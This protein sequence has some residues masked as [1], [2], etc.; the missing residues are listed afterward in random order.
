MCNK[1]TS[2][3]NL[4]DKLHDEELTKKHHRTFKF[5]R[6]YDEKDPISLVECM[7]NQLMELDHTRKSLKTFREYL[8]EHDVLQEFA[9]QERDN[10]LE[11]I[12]G[13]LNQTFDEMDL[14]PSL[15]E[16]AAHLLYMVI[17]RH[18]FKDGNKRSA[19]F[20][21]IKFL[22]YNKEYNEYVSDLDDV[23]LAC[24]VLLIAQSVPEQKDDVIW[25]IR[26]IL[27]TRTTNFLHF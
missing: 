21:L 24:M 8:Q 11:A 16:K 13:A 22:D 9:I 23:L 5:L 12:W 3:Y 10:G 26:Q 15:E 25:T 20:L 27:S 2:R 17:K 18:P 19:A 14:Y 7:S 1:P 4:L 6:M